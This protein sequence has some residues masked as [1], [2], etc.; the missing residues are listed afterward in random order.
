V[1]GSGVRRQNYTL[2]LIAA[3]P[4][5]RWTYIGFALTKIPVAGL[6]PTSNRRFYSSYNLLLLRDF[7]LIF[8]RFLRSNGSTGIYVSWGKPARSDIR[9]AR[10]NGTAYAMMGLVAG[11]FRL[12]TFLDRL[13]AW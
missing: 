8:C 9:L 5:P 10:G 2:M 4:A 7:R 11:G 12:A 13:K 1:D 6:P 3:W